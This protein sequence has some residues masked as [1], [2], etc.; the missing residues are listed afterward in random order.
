MVPSHGL[1]PCSQEEIKVPVSGTHTYEVWAPASNTSQIDSFDPL[2]PKVGRAVAITRHTASGSLI[3]SL[4]QV[5][6][7]KRQPGTLNCWILTRKQ[8]N[9]SPRVPAPVLVQPGWVLLIN[10]T[11]L[12]IL[13]SPVITLLYPHSPPVIHLSSLP[14]LQ[15]SHTHC[16]TP[17]L[18]TPKD[19]VFLNTPRLRC[20]SPPLHTHVG[21]THTC[22]RCGGTQGRIARCVRMC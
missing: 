18:L 7:S 10:S 12:S 1:L 14:G 4:N 15:D 8:Q 19:E 3:T 9:P 21:P 11:L 6:A 5:Y 2:D 17:E 20:M 22:I 13:S 16:K